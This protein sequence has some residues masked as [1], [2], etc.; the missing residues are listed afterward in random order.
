MDGHG[1]LTFERVFESGTRVNEE[2]L[3]LVVEELFVVS[4]DRLLHHVVEELVLDE[5]RAGKQARC[6]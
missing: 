6:T 2:K 1:L 5:A 4:L 3:S